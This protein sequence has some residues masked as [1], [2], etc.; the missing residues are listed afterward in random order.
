MVDDELILAV[1]IIGVAY[2]AF[3][4]KH[5]DPDTGYALPRSSPHHLSKVGHGVR[6]RSVKYAGSD[7]YMHDVSSNRFTTFSRLP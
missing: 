4:P 1:L 6:N 7:K 2:W 3:T 5:I